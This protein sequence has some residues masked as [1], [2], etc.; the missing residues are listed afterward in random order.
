MT[1]ALL[2]SVAL[3]YGF[4]VVGLAVSCFYFALWLSGARERERAFYLL[5][6][7]ATASAC[8]SPGTLEQKFSNPF[9]AGT[10]DAHHIE[11]LARVKADRL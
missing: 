6:V 7:A 11:W 8:S 4:L 3:A 1:Y 2:V 10:R 9:F 5:A